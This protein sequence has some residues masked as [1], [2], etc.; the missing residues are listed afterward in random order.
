ME[1]Y[2]SSIYSSNK[3]PWSLTLAELS[4]AM[5]TKR[6][7]YPTSSSPTSS[8]RTRASPLTQDTSFSS[9]AQTGYQTFS[10]IDPT[11]GQRSAFPGLD[12]STA[13]VHNGAGEYEDPTTFE[14]LQYLRSVR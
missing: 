5:A 14:A 9:D 4:H 10:R 12:H 2:D 7:D 3:S 11:Y 13:A 1:L 8:K 6:K